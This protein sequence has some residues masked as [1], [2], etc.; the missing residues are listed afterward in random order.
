MPIYRSDMLG[1]SGRAL[2][3]FSVSLSCIYLCYGR[4]HNL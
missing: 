3:Y 4:T 2:I 1:K